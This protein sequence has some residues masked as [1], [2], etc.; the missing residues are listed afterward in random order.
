MSRGFTLLEVLMAMAMMSVLAVSLFST[1]HVAF[2]ARQAAQAALEPMHKLS[3]SLNMVADELRGALPITGMLALEF[4]GED[5]QTGQGL[6][7]DSILFY[8][9]RT[10]APWEGHDTGFREVEILLVPDPDE[11]DVQMLVRHTRP[12]PLTPVRPEPDE[13]VICRG[14]RSLTVQ[15]Y[16]GSTWRDEWDS[17]TEGAMLPYAVQLTLELMPDPDRVQ[18]DDAEGGRSMTM[19]AVL[20]N[21]SA[22]PLEGGGG[23][24]RR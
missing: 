19:T 6:A 17:E 11:N 13:L 23:Q 5:N 22:A 4:I 10:H 3:L 16:D 15:Y 14:V 21:A 24:I 7:N 1:L 20:M 9:A 12:T 2:R 18:Q 8:T